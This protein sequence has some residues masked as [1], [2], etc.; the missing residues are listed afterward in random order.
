MKVEPY[1]QCQDC[2]R[3]LANTTVYRQ[4]AYCTDCGLMSVN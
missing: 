1:Q 4:H 3:P 2:G